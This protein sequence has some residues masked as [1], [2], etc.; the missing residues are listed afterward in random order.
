[1]NEEK[2]SK[3]PF[4]LGLTS[5]IAIVSLIGFFVMLGLFLSKDVKIAGNDTDIAGEKVANAEDNQPSNPEEPQKTSFNISSSDHIRGNVDAKVTI[6]EFSD[7]QCPFCSRF[8]ETMKQVMTEY[9]DDVRWVYKHFPL[10]SLHPEARPSAMASECA[11]EQGKFWEYGDKLIENQ[12]S[13]STDTYKSIAVELGLNTSQFNTCLDTQ[14]YADKVEQDY[15]EGLAKGVRGTP[16]NFVNGSSLPGAVPFAQVKA[17]I[18]Q[19]L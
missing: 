18:D 1:M 16:G 3:V 15:Q 17:L 14:K 4:L 2:S 13:L 7:F 10:D 8:H 5:G 19:N 6:V 9:S 12:A 11:A